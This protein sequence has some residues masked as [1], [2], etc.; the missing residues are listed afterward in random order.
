MDG[1]GDG[2]KE[3]VIETGQ[4]TPAGSF[5]NK[6]SKWGWGITLGILAVVFIFFI[7]S[8]CGVLFLIALGEPLKNMF[9]NPIVEIEQGEGASMLS[10]IIYDDAPMTSVPMTSNDGDLDLEPI[11]V[12]R[13]SE[14]GETVT[15][16]LHVFLASDGLAQV[17][18]FVNQ[19]EIRSDIEALL[20]ETPLEDLEGYGNRNELIEE[21]K[22]IAN[23][24][25]SGGETVRD[26]YF[27]EYD[28]R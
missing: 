24:Y 2:I 13:Q 18:L 9:S 15:I 28:V 10:S 27:A 20:M 22:S 25:L 6:T 14:T 12:V 21:I 19:D 16:T 7:L 26:V 23:G 5:E 1:F 11:T 8:C 4:P 17:D 3:P